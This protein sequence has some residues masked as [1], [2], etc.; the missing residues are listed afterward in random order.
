MEAYS[1]SSWMAVFTAL[2]GAAAALTGLLF[3]ALSINLTQVLKQPGLVPRAVEVLILLVAVLIVSTL[4][5][6]PSQPSDAVGS[7]ILTVA[8]VAEIMVTYIHVRAPRRSLGVTGQQFAL[9]VAGAQVGLIL[10][11]AGGVSVL[12]H[13]GGGLYWVV[14]ALL[15]AVVAAIIGAWVLLV[16]ILR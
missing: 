8:V 5:L 14:P 6:M 9:R 3:V 15:F 2:A 10:L 7:E 4:L 16:E 1:T 11:I 12:V 13:S